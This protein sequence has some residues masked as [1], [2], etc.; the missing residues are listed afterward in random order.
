MKYYLSGIKLTLQT[1]INKKGLFLTNSFVM[2]CSLLGR[3][4]FFTA[5][6]FQISDLNIATMAAEEKDFNL[7]ES[8]REVDNIKTNW[9]LLLVNI[10]K[11]IFIIVA[12][13]FVLGATYLFQKFGLELNVK[14]DFYG[15]ELFFSVPIV[16][17][18]AISVIFILTLFSPMTYIAL[19]AK[20]KSIFNVMYNT[21]VSMNF[22]NSLN[23]MIIIILTLIGVVIMPIGGF[24]IIKQF[25]LDDSYLE[26]IFV[27]IYILVSLLVI[28]F[29]LLS[30]QVAFY[31]FCKENISLDQK[32][33]KKEKVTGASDEE[34]LTS[35][36]RNSDL[37]K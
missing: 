17:L 27:V 12:C 2:L 16:T 31:E 34:K 22:K 24:V 20:D 36:F 32:L 35:I 28:S 7:F 18:G 21:K 1:Y 33:A 5:P 11:L 25:G 3:L 30:G 6:V 26:L 23:V 19:N 13:A 29:S 37:V 9:T 10:I 8:F 4:L 14:S 15:L